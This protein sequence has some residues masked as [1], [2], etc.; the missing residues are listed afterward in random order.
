MKNKA[1][2]T[3]KLLVVLTLPVASLYGQSGK[4]QL[5]KLDH[6]RLLESPFKQAEQ[7]DLNYILKME[8]DRLLAPYLRE[9]GLVPQ[10]ESYG[11]WENSGLDGHTG[12]HYLT[13]LAQ[14]YASAGNMECKH[15][16]DYM[17][18]ELARCQEKNGNGYVGG[19]PGGNRMWAQLKTG[20]LSDFNTKWVPWYN[21]HKLYAGLRDAYLLAGNAKAKA[22]FIK[23]CDWADSEVAGLNT[24]QMQQML[25]TE[26]GG[27]NEVFADA[28]A[29]TGDKKYLALAEKFSHRAILVPLERHEDKLSG[30]H[31]NTQIP[32]VIGFERIA[33]LSNDTGYSSAA[34]FFWNTV[35]NKRSIAIGGNSVREHFNPVNDFATMLE[36]E[37][38]PETCNS[39]NMLKLSKMLFVDDTR[40]A[41]ID[42]YERLLYNHILSSQH[43]VTGGFVYFTPIHPQHYRVY[44][45]ADQ[46]FWCCVG[47]G[48]ENHGKYGE[49]IYSHKGDDLYVNLFIPSVLN[50]KEKGFEVT[51][52]TKFPDA[53]STSLSL[54]LSRPGK[55]AIYIRKPGWL[56]SDGFN[57]TINNR[58]VK[59]T[60]NAEGY[61]K[62]VHPWKTG[63][64]ITVSLPMKTSV[65]YLPD[66]SAWVSFLRGPIVLAAPT[67]TTQLTGL[68]AGDS[69]WGHI[70]GGPLYPLPASPLLAG[71]GTD[72]VTKV[73]AVAGAAPLTYKISDLVVQPKF[74][75]LKLIP[76]YKVHDSRYMLYWPVAKPDSIQQR[77]QELALL[78]ER[79]IKLAARSVDAVAPGEQQPENDH[80]MIAEKSETG[81]FRNLHWRSA[82]GFFSYRLRTNADVKVLGITYYGRENGREFD[83]YLDDLKLAHV[84]LN[85]TGPD[86][87]VT[88]EYAIPES[89]KTNAGAITVKFVAADGNKTAAIYGVRLMR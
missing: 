77:E 55:F 56:S 50:W 3:I 51:Q 13:A 58:A 10:A 19:V 61:V 63:D 39:N 71:S 5:F 46:S 21:L 72:L 26:H 42:F 64:R 12:G 11:N 36:S 54:K 74:K 44:S 60:H 83:I 81:I 85:G 87:F 18:N 1:V 89:L 78:D 7:V 86:T 31:A 24:T 49:L 75:N 41:Y 14:M 67:D 15:R 48:I 27:M 16:L 29:I 4:M 68:F 34:R 32:K 66:H 43:P 82:T 25:G 23:L 80:G 47:T 40:L 88:K 59:Y 17:V 35:V 70:A 52:Q 65:E 33:G 28:Y 45:T 2:L 73:K 62:L 20:D 84:S 38:G 76:F 22:V 69:R 79:Y 8:P 57:V 9:A 30:L 6:V 53:G 37:Q